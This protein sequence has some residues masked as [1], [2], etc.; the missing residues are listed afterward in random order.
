[1]RIITKIITSIIICFLI[2]TVGYSIY[3]FNTPLAQEHIITP[4]I[5][6]DM[7]IGKRTLTVSEINFKTYWD[8]VYTEGYANLPE[9]S[10]NLGD[11]I[12]NCFGT[13]K[14]FFSEYHLGSWE[15][16]ETTDSFDDVLFIGEWVGGNQEY[17]FYTDGSI[18]F[19]GP[20]EYG[21]AEGAMISINGTYKNADLSKSLAVQIESADIKLFSYIFEEDGN[22]LLLFDE[23]ESYKYS[24]QINKIRTL[25]NVVDYSSQKV[26][27]TGKLTADENETIGYLSI[28]ETFDVIVFFN[29]YSEGNAI[30]YNGKK[31]EIIGFIFKANENDIWDTP[32]IDYIK[33]IRVIDE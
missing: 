11:V 13:V 27:I 33:S 8:Y 10:I 20:E 22:T 16:D 6:F 25:Q 21:A 15:F 17:E 28:D 4:V 1:M 23:N 32:Y 12:S 14:L 18:M 19:N 30:M 7:D 5:D 3:I 24:R 2:V 29:N 9:G 31:V 26:N